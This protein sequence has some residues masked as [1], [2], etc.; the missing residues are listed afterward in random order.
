MLWFKN[1]MLFVVELIIYMKIFTILHFVISIVLIQ[2]DFAS[3]GL[4]SKIS[5]DSASCYNFK[6]WL[7]KC[8]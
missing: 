8:Y 1:V 3:S 4:C 7:L 5:V 6:F 2:C